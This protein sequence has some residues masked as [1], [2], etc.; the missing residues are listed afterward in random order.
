M[1]KELLFIYKSGREDVHGF[2]FSS[3]IIVTAARSSGQVQRQACQ[4]LKCP[5]KF[6][7]FFFLNCIAF[8]VFWKP[9][10][11]LYR[12]IEPMSLCKWNSK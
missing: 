7:S 3:D 11:M 8:S 12:L 4:M 6:T 2:W 9:L 1:G 10:I 5:I